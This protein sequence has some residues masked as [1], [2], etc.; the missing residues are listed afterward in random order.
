MKKPEI[1]LFSLTQDSVN[2]L[3]TKCLQCLLR[4]ARLVSTTWETEGLCEVCETDGA[5][6]LHFIHL[7]DCF[8]ISFFTPLHF[9]C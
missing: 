3:Y 7:S 4:D 1:V 8:L 2:A 6:Q 9:R 5:L